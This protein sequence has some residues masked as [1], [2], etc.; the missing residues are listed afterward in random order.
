MSE[1]TLFSLFRIST[2]KKFAKYPDMHFSGQ[3]F[4]IAKK[5]RK[6]GGGSNPLIRIFP[7]PCPSLREGSLKATALSLRGG[8]SFS[9]D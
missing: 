8:E 3:I 4:R 7:S 1:Q 5:L 9:T 6:I 2:C